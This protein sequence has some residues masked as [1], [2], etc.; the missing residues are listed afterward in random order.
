MPPRIAALGNGS[1]AVVI[2]DA[3]GVV[4]RTTFTEG[5]TN[6]WQPWVQVGG[7]LQ[8]V[9]PAGMGGQ[10]YLAG[11]APGGGLVVVAADRES[12]DVDREQRRRGGSV[13]CRRDRR[14]VAEAAGSRGAIRAAEATSEPG[15]IVGGGVF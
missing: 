10:L 1:E 11:K 15:R 12:M 2:L 7:V 6:G 4:Y 3:T 9:A 14:P 5:A 13:V 8:D